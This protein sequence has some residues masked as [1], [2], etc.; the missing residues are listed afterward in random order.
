MEVWQYLHDADLSMWTVYRDK[1]RSCW[2]NT[3]TNI[4]ESLNNVLR[5]ARIIQIK[6]C[7]E[8]SFDYTRQHFYDQS[9]EARQCNSPLSKNMFNTFNEGAKRAQRY[10]TTCYNELQGVFKIQSS[11]QRSG[12]GGT[13]YT[14]EY[15]KKKC[16][17]GIWK[18]QRLPCS[19][20]ISVCSLL[21][22]D[23]ITLC[24]KK[25]TTTVWREQYS[26][27]FKPLRDASYWHLL[28]GTLWQIQQD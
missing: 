21:H 15:K 9:R 24:S 7:I 14:L 11:Y 1:D 28:T 27:H 23:V 13:D 19:H 2:G 26:H 10:N 5:Y 20:V 18:Y 6:T 17:C 25:Y 22:E 12:E 3:T 8:Y 4:D 16:S